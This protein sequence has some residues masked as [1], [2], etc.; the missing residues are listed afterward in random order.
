MSE[1]LERTSH[2][3]GTPL[4]RA[5]LRLTIGAATT[6]TVAIAAIAITIGGV[7]LHGVVSPTRLGS[8]AGQGE[9][10]LLGMVLLISPLPGIAAAWRPV[11]GLV[12]ALLL[13]GALTAVHLAVI[14]GS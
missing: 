1:P 10:I 12:L 8:G 6:V 9:G 11:A 4:E 3:D 14:A 2:A 7:W 13:L 5:L